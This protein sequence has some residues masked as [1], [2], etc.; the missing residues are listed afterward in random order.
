MPPEDGGRIGTHFTEWLGSPLALIAT[1][2]DAI[3]GH[4][5]PVCGPRNRRRADV[6]AA[7]DIGKR[8]I[9]PRRWGTRRS[10]LRLS[11]AKAIKRRDLAAST[12]PSS[13]R[14]Y[15]IDRDVS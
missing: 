7:P 4:C 13:T 9:T 15:R 11:A 1:Y 6:V 14:V 10:S 2:T 12:L 8:F 3:C 5:A